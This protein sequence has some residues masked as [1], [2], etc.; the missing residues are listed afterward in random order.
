MFKN[1]FINS[2]TK[3]SL[4][5]KNFELKRGGTATDLKPLPINLIKRKQ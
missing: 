1:N 4:E 5:A 2:E 3:I